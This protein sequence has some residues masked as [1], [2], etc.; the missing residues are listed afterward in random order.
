MPQP[1]R[2][3][4]LSLEAR[5][6]GKEADV[7][8]PAVGRRTSRRRHEA[9]NAVG[10]SPSTRSSTTRSS[11]ES[12]SG[13]TESER[14]QRPKKA[15]SRERVGRPAPAPLPDQTLRAL[16]SHQRVPAAHVPDASFSR[17]VLKVMT[18]AGCICFALGYV[19][20]VAYLV[21]A[22]LKERASTNEEVPEASLACA[23]VICPRETHCV[24]D[25]ESGRPRCTAGGS[26]QN[27]ETM[28]LILAIMLGVPAAICVPCTL[29]Y[30]LLKG[31]PKVQ[32]SLGRPTPGDPGLDL[33]GGQARQ[34][35][36]KVGAMGFMRG[37]LE[38]LGWEAAQPVVVQA[39]AGLVKQAAPVAT[40]RAPL[41][42]DEDELAGFFTQVRKEGKTPEAA[43]PD[44]TEEQ[45]E[46][47][48][49]QD[50]LE[51][52]FGHWPGRPVR[53]AQQEGVLVRPKK[54]KK[55]KKRRKERRREEEDEEEIPEDDPLDAI[56]SKSKRKAEEE[57]SVDPLDEIF[58]KAVRPRAAQKNGGGSEIDG[59]FG[60]SKKKPEERQRRQGGSRPRGAMED[61]SDLDGMGLLFSKPQKPR[62]RP[63]SRVSSRGCSVATG[64]NSSMLRLDTLLQKADVGDEDDEEGPD[65]MGYGLLV[66]RLKAGISEEEQLAE[67]GDSDDSQ[68]ELQPGPLHELFHAPLD[69]A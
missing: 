13:R 44:D 4:D 42:S 30:L 38:V 36:V 67:G 54:E 64:A 59:I 23:A 48:G 21:L 10:P 45:S 56:F 37:A 40:Q 22:V 17:R 66:A 12:R 61:S 65:F 57:G 8:T 2:G 52:L 51:D 15:G 16:A 3:P 7:D 28:E 68:A 53:E 9:G 6:L 29:H 1:P 62:R 46:P 31:C 26:S 47:E 19:V 41:S 63:A 39:P 11:R 32:K 49:S 34:V 55:E 33:E 24:T 14:R 58:C 69:D 20:A 60:S 50:G 35:T 5:T 18:V 43:R 27:V 25:G